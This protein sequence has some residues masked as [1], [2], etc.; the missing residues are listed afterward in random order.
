MRQIDYIVIHCTATKSNV[1]TSSILNYWYN[2]LGWKNPG[3][4]WIIDSD[5]HITPLQNL[6][7]PSNGVKGYNKKAIHIS[8]KGGIAGNDTRT[9][10]QRAAILTCIHE[11]LTYANKTGSK[12]KI[13]GHR[14]F[15]GVTKDCPSF[16]AEHEY[17]WI[18]V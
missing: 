17:Y 1:K 13:L 3:Y 14:D 5:G 4:H 8:Y 7:K 11:A 18:T 2:V 10:E 6:D 12:P 16:D 15:P 9:A